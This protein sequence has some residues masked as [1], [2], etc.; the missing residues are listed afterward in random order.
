M[1][2]GIEYTV[3][4]EFLNS[5]WGYPDTLDTVSFT[6]GDRFD[7]AG[8]AFSGLQRVGLSEQAEAVQ[9][10][11]ESTD[12]YCLGMCGPCQ[13]CWTTGWEYL[14]L[15]QLSF[16]AVEDEFGPSS[17][18]YAIYELDS[19]DGDLGEPKLI[20][21][22]E[23]AGEQNINLVVDGAGPHC[24]AVRAHDAYGRWDSNS[25]VMCVGSDEKVPV[26]RLDVP[27]P[28]RQY[29]AETQGDDAG[30][31]TG[32]SDVGVDSGEDAAPN[33]DTA[34]A[35]DAGPT[36]ISTGS[37]DDGCGCTVGSTAAAPWSLLFAAFGIAAA[38]VRR[39]Q[40]PRT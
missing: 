36:E 8:P 10:C 29:C 9:D 2:E 19:L 13:W 23:T 32:V 1:A 34:D 22:P 37:S 20:V 12:D 30:V 14:P 11:C 4:I 31:D 21:S 16:R 24:F 15:A 35:G 5:T 39:R 7:E 3:H 33:E 26:T 17:V 28:D 38:L 18:R 6:T 27:P 25:T 40:Q